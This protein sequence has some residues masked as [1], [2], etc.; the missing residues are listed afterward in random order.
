[1]AEIIKI[2][3][4]GEHVSLSNGTNISRL[5]E[6]EKLDP[7]VVVAELNGNILSCDAF[8]TT[9]LKQD[10]ILELLHFVGGG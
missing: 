10:D 3:L 1:M 5:L 7:K 6:L 8:E 4:N 2:I 9:I